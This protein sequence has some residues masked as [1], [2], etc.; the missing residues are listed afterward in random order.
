MPSVPHLQLL[1]TLV[2]CQIYTLKYLKCIAGLFHVG[3]AKPKNVF[4]T[5][6]KFL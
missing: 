5:S 3:I 1:V 6:N 2:E 4:R